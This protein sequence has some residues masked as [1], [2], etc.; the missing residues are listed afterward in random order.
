M[1][2]Q[3]NFN[4]RFKVDIPHRS[5]WHEGYVD[6]A[7]EVNF[8]TDGS[9]TEEGVGSAV[10]FKDLH[11]NLS[12]RLPD[13]CSIFQ[14]EIIAI[15]KA[16]K[17]ALS[18]QTAGKT[19]CIFV[20]S[21]AALKALNLNQIKSK[22][23]MDCF[24]T[25]QLLGANSRVRLCWVPGHSDVT[26]NEIADSL[27]REGSALCSSNAEDVPLPISVAYKRTLSRMYTTAEE[28]WAQTSSC[29]ITKV[30]W[31]SSNFN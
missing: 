12:Y 27:A 13:Q 19:I 7:D 21:Q 8:Y 9:K 15:Y 1:I 30:M 14:A 25:L 23:T 31:G 4:H 29:R 6:P 11:L 20:Y 24:Q 16:A 17:S 2:P 26:G 28:T 5:F 22:T 18:S 3:L 10:F